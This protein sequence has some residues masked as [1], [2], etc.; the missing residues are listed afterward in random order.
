MIV[1]D[2]HV[3]IWDALKPEALSNQ[4]REAIA[5]ANERDG[6]IF[7]DISLW[8]I[9]M[10]VAKGRLQ[11]DMDYPSLIELILQANHYVLQ[12]ISPAIAHLATQL[13]ANVNQ[14]PAD[15]LIAATALV[16]QAVLVTADRNLRGTEIIPTLW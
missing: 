12:P 8:E 9:A 16:E 1:L 7:C 3:I 15:R 14:D 5:D 11:I 13:P 6:I 4:A 2:T 10:L